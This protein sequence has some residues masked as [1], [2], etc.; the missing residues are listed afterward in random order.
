[1]NPQSAI[2]NLSVRSAV[3]LSFGQFLK[4][5]LAAKALVLH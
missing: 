4:L 2:L 3:D 1:V 5:Q